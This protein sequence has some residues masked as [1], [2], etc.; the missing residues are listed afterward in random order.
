MT[1]NSFSEYILD[2]NE[3]YV[4]IT[5]AWLLLLKMGIK[6][7]KHAPS[8]SYFLGV[9][10]WCYHLLREGWAFELILVE[11]VRGSSMSFLSWWIWAWRQGLPLMGLCNLGTSCLRSV[12]LYCLHL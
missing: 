6:V 7:S 4:S 5:I 11:P 9:C 8:W 3:G 10:G 2:R 1:S 12:S